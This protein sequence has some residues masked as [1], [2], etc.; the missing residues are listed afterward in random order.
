MFG[1]IV[2]ILPTEISLCSSLKNQRNEK[3]NIV[4]LLLLLSNNGYAGSM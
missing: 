4:G 1:E 2:V 3:R